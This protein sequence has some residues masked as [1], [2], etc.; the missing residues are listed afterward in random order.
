VQPFKLADP[1]KNGHRKI[2]ALFLVDPGIRIISTANVPPQQKDWWFDEIL[3]Q[4]ARSG[5]ALAKLSAEL[6]YKIFDDVEEFPI[7]MEEAKKVRLKLMHERKA[8]VTTHT[9]TAF[10]GN[11]FNLCEH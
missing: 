4:T 2:L 7:G 6:K 1:T 3:G 8:Y 10:E 5:K 11:T 9:S